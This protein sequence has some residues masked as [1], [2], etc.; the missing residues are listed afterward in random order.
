M[1][2]IVCAVVVAGTAMRYAVV[3]RIVATKLQI[4]VTSSL[5]SAWFSPSNYIFS[6]KTIS[7]DI[8]LLTIGEA[9]FF[10]KICR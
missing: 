8:E 5:G 1:G 10:E 9:D 3:R 7:T 6:E 4:A 2:R